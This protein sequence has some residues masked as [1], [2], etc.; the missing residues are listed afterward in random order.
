MLTNRPLDGLSY[1]IDLSCI[2]VDSVLSLY[3]LSLCILRLVRV[4]RVILI[5]AINVINALIAVLTVY[6]VVNISL[7]IAFYSR[8][9]PTIIIVIIITIVA[10]IIIYSLLCIQRELS[11]IGI[12]FLK[13]VSETLAS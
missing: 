8:A 6:N 3:I 4:A 2:V 12:I 13:R 1:V 5:V 7:T 10:L 11:I 9:I